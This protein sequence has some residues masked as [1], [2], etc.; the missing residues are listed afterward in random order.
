MHNI[1]DEC[2][3][4]DKKKVNRYIREMKL[5]TMDKL[6][7]LYNRMQLPSVQKGDIKVE[8]KDEFKAENL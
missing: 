8:M 5:N 3:F 7:Y 6:P 4:K 1:I 2:E